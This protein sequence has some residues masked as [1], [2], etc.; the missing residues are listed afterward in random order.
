MKDTFDDIFGDEALEALPTDKENTEAKRIRAVRHAIKTKRSKNAQWYE[1]IRNFNKNRDRKESSRL[2][3]ERHEDKEFTSNLIKSALAS[4]ET[5]EYW[6]NYKAGI[7]KRNKENKEWARN[8]AK[9]KKASVPNIVTPYGIYQSCNEF[10]EMSKAFNNGHGIS[11]GSK[12]RQMPHLYYYEHEGPGE[13]TYEYVYHTPLGKFKTEREAVEAQRKIQPDLPVTW[14]RQVTRKY[15]DEYYRTKEI[16][17]EWDLF[18]P[19][20]DPKNDK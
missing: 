4:R 20:N 19:K 6:Q 11:F 8:V 1:N 15:S 9:G 16:R 13:P 12:Q 3:K 10:A 17:I 5:E 14:W 2:M 7:E 18:D